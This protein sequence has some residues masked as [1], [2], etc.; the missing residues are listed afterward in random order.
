MRV[1]SKIY[2]GLLIT[3]I[4]GLVGP[5]QALGLGDLAGVVL[6]GNSVLKKSE[7]KCGTS[8][9][10]T[11]AENLIVSQAR[12]AVFKSIPAAEFTQLDASAEA[13]ADASAQSSTFCPETKTKKKGILS[14]IKK[15]GKAI[16]AGG[17]LLGI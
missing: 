13:S 16:L 3:A 14:G 9:K 7:Q 17:K 15:A 10:L 4:V 1:K 8:A 11:S 2:A 6:K 5:A 12:N